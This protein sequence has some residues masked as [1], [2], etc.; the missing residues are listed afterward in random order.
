MLPA[1]LVAAVVLVGLLVGA[2]LFA[3]WGTRW[4]STP[5]ERAAEMTADDF[6]SANAAAHVAMTR[7]LDIDAAPETVWAWL[8]QTGRGAG[9]YSYDRLDNGGR[10]SARHIVSWIP[11]P[12]EGDASAIGYLRSLA[13]GRELA[14]WAPGVRFA[15]AESSLAVEMRLSDRG[16][17]SRL[18]IRIS[19]D[20]FGLM[21]HPC[22]WIFRLIDSIMAIRQLVRIKEYAERWATR[23]VDPEDPETGSRAQYQL[24]QVVYASG[25]WAGTYGRE[26]ARH[27]HQLGLEARGE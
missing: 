22:L 9:W 3:R 14:W 19:A 5:E 12:A 17:G 27:W 26:K 23:T 7:A 18:V 24:Y 25:E 21:A 8:A 6:F 16:E 13:P 2:T 1:V 10:R 11:Q 4:G 20:A 15:G